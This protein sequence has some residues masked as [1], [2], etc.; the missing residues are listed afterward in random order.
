MA[1][2]TSRGW[3]E[4][5][6][7]HDGMV[8]ATCAAVDAEAAKGAA[9][10]PEPDRIFAA[11]AETPLDS[12]KVILLG[13]DPYPTPGDADGL[14]FSCSGPG[15]LPRSLANIYRELAADLDAT[16]PSH[17]DLAPWARQGVLLLNTAL[18]VAS[19]AGQAGSHLKLG[20]D[21]VTDALIAAACARNAHLVVMLWGAAAQRRR[22]LIDETR[23]LV[24]ASAHPSP[25]SARHG[26]FGSKPF[27]RANAF[28]Q[29]HGMAPINWC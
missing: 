18:T 2:E 15:R 27:S 26:F 11:F 19:G 8:R 20:W 5:T 10:A 28:L 4:L 25:L 3:R 1:S 17:G 21:G 24:I 29:S 12:V 9:I 6:P 16:P 22:P 7:F 13:Q 23:H 14:A